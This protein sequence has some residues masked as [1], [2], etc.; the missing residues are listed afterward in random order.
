M[1]A[2]KKLS[3]AEIQNV[4]KI[5][6]KALKRI[7]S[8]PITTPYIEV[9]TETGVWPTEQ[10][11]NHICHSIINS[12]KDRLVKQIIQEQGAQKHSNTFYNKVKAIAEELNLKL[13][14]GVIMKK[15]DWKRTVKDKT[16]NQI[17]ERVEKEMENKTKLRTVR[18]DKWER[19]EYITTCDSDLVKD[20]IKI[21]LH[22]W[23][24][25][26]NYPREEEGKKCPI[27]NQKEDITEHVLERQTTEKEYKI[28]DNTP[29]QWAEV[30]KLYRRNKELRK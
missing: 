6:G 18:E 22:M 23:E 27:C 4:E 15:S 28:R 21:R 12:S 25:K 10:R 9:I 26:K 14:K 13:E 24:L 1:E 7:F 20:I 19:K 11:I 17:Q 8:L 30:V 3:K 29:N 2:W 16:Q 5:Q